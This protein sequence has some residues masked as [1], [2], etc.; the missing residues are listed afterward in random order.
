ME[1]QFVVLLK[2][3]VIHQVLWIWIAGP[4]IHISCLTEMEGDPP[5]LTRMK[6]LGVIPCMNQGTAI[7]TR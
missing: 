1:T 3:M 5:S 6:I 7:A 4:V 2:G